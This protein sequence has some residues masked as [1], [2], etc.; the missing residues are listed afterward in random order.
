MQ[1]LKLKLINGEITYPFPG[2]CWYSGGIYNS[3]SHFAIFSVFVWK[4]KILD[5]GLHSNSVKTQAIRT[6]I[7]VKFQNGCVEFKLFQSTVFYNR[8]ELV[9]SN[10]VVSYRQNSDIEHMQENRHNFDD[11]SFSNRPTV[12]LRI[13]PCS[14][15]YV[16]F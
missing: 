8:F 14:N 15:V 11:R 16:T 13:C 9:F 7:S 12:F 1:A 10:C 6:R 3:A 4:A 2:T 5:P